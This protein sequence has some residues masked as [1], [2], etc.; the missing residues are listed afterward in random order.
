MEV[1]AFTT[2]TNVVIAKFMYEYIF[3]KFSYLLTLVTNYIIHFISDVIK[4]LTNHFLLKHVSSTTYYP[5]ENGQAKSTNKFI[6]NFIIKLINE[7]IKQIGMNIYLLHF[8]H[9]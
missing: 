8:F 6:V 7:V 3:V 5:Q 2:N 9:V 4:Y 1:K